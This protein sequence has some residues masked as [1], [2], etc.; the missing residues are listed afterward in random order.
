MSKNIWYYKVYG[1]EF[2]CARHATKTQRVKYLYVFSVCGVLI[3]ITRLRDFPQHKSL[4]SR[5]GLR[6]V[7]VLQKSVNSK[8]LVTDLAL[9]RSNTAQDRLISR[10]NWG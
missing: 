8:D 7:M 6:L 3:G 9:A 5:K 1:G 10:E 4:D 2:I